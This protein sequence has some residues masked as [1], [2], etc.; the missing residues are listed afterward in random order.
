M[1]ARFCFRVTVNGGF[2]VHKYDVLPNV[3]Q[4]A[5]KIDIRPAH[6]ERLAAS[7]P[8]TQD[9]IR[10][11]TK[12]CGCTSFDGLDGLFLRRHTL[13][14]FEVLGQRDIFG[15]V[16]LCVPLHDGEFIH[17]PDDD[18]LR[19]DRFCRELLQGERI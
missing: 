16:R 17:K 18:L 5:F 2:V 9:K 6:C 15:G 4:V 11:Q 19:L 8:C 13:F 7:A 10:E 3:D 14:G 1:Y 12:R